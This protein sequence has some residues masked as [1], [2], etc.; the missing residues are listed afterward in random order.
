M[1]KYLIRG[2]KKTETKP[3]QWCSWTGQENRH[4]LKYRKL[5]LNIRRKILHRKG[6]TGF[7]GKLWSPSLEKP[8]PQ[9]DMALSE[10]LQSVLSWPVGLGALQES[11]AT[12]ASCDTA[13][14]CVCA[15]GLSCMCC[16]EPTLLR[17]RKGWMGSSERGQGLR[18]WS[19]Q[20]PRGREGSRMGPLQSLLTFSSQ[21]GCGGGMP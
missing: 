5:Q 2:A 18:G 6:D 10:L 12:S 19:R 8:K 16:Q 21:Q 15:L 17:D 4:E 14:M 20:A 3:S 1:Y 11:F 13:I 9:W 7:S